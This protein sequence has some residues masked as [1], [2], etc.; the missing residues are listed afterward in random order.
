MAA[1]FRLRV[2]N[3]ALW[4]RWKIMLCASSACGTVRSVQLTGS[5]GSRVPYFNA[6]GI[7]ASGML[8]RLDRTYTRVSCCDRMTI[9][10]RK[11]RIRLPFRCVGLP[12]ARESL[13]RLGCESE[14]SHIPKL[15][16]RGFHRQC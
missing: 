6:E 2:G 15:K 16:C 4:S 14:Q 13:R 8:S 10:L 12:A 5:V 7:C 1:S 3:Y 9:R 11:Q